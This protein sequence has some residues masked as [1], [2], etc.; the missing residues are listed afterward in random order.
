MAGC[1]IISNTSAHGR[2]LSSGPCA[3]PYALAR[4]GRSVALQPTRSGI[5]LVAGQLLT[6][7]TLDYV[8]I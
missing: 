7:N 2:F 8:F 6:I 1:F 5:G 4:Q 3:G